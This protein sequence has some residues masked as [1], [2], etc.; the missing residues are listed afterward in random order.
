MQTAQYQRNGVAAAPIMQ[1]RQPAIDLF[2]RAM[3]VR[4]VYNELDAIVFNPE[5]AAEQRPAFT[6]A[7]SMGFQFRSP[8]WR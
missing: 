2:P 8:Y 6:A 1:R 3:V 5:A 4:N 7:T